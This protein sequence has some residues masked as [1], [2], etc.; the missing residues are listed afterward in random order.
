MHLQEKKK[1]SKVRGPGREKDFS[2]FSI[3]LRSALFLPIPRKWLNAFLTDS[4]STACPSFR[5]KK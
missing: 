3:E 2:C 4:I 1:R 5:T